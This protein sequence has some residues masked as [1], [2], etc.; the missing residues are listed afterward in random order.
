MAA[1]PLV[2]LSN[3]DGFH[4]PGIQEL[5]ASLSA[6]F[7]VVVVAPEREQSANSHAISLARPLRHRTV[8]PGVHVVDGTPVD[9]IYVA[10]F[11]EGLLPRTPDLILSG[12]NHGANL[13]SDVHYSGTVAAAREG[14]LRAIP[15]VAFSTMAPPPLIGSNA[16]MALELTWRLWEGRDEGALA[17]DGQTLLLNINFPV[18]PPAGLRSTVL[19]RRHYSDAV[20]IRVDPRGR[21]YFW[22]GGPGD[23]RHEPLSGSDTDAVDAGYVSITPLTIEASHPP[24]APVADF[25]AA[26]DFLAI[27]ADQRPGSH[28]E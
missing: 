28:D 20:D 18:V 6:R 13:G 10:L 25:L 16:A 3:D 4:A 7:D 12:I 24:H 23:T 17:P 9:C 1:R 22:I 2:L 8:E 21:E 11:H 5:R 26:T 14:A 19:G 15:S 27:R